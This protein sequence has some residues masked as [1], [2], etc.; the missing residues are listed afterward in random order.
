M[1]EPVVIVPYDAH[2][3]TEFNTIAKKLREAIRDEA[4]RIDHIGSTAVPGLDAKPVIDIQ[5]SVNKLE[6]MAY[7]SALEVVGYRCRSN[8]PDLTK[9][10]FREKQGMRRTHIHVREAGSW[11]EQF[12]LLFRDFLRQ[13][14][15]W[16]QLYAKEKHVLAQRYSTPHERELYVDGKET[17]VWKIMQEASRWSQQTGWKPAASDY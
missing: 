11:S 13:S 8:N 2:W 12:A 10:Y 17:I 9:R 7:R 3:Q 1:Q 6:P 15:E 5:I 4:L 14:K 16:Q